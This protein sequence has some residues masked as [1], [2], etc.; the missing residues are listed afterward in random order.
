MRVL[1]AQLTLL[2]LCLSPVSYSFS[3]SNL[4][5]YHNLVLRPSSGSTICTKMPSAANVCPNH[6]RAKAV[7]AFRDWM[8]CKKRDGGEE[9]DPDDRIVDRHSDKTKSGMDDLQPDEQVIEKWVEK[10]ETSLESA[11]KNERYSE[12]ST[13][14]DELSRMHMDDTSA[15]LKT[16]SDFYNAFSTKNIELMGTVWH[17]SPHVQCIHPGAK[18]LLGYDNIVNMWRNMFQARDKAFKSTA[19]TPSNVKVH[20]RGTSAFVTCTE[21]VSSPGTERRM[22]A[23]NV[24]RKLGGRWYLVHHHASQASVRPASIED[25]LQGNSGGA[26]VIRFDASSLREGDGHANADEIVD[27]IVRALQGALENAE[28]A[29][30]SSNGEGS[31]MVGS[32]MFELS[33]DDK[34]DDMRRGLRDDGRDLGDDVRVQEGR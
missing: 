26:R 10:L 25:L 7:S 33:D 18:P 8:C 9:L 13:L 4:P 24:F 15:V 23:T 27:E 17:N 1:V 29:N 6:C 20:V 11:V 31:G 5:H 14:R 34:D 3:V 32:M 16:N 2:G 12:A 30:Q 21:E 22:L 19:I 28:E